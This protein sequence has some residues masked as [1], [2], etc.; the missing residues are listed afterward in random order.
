MLRELLLLTTTNKL[1]FASAIHGPYSAQ[2]HSNSV[3]AGELLSNN[4]SYKVTNNSTFEIQISPRDICGTERFQNARSRN[5]SLTNTS[6]AE[7][8]QELTLASNGERRAMMMAN[9]NKAASEMEALLNSGNNRRGL[10]SRPRA[11]TT[12]DTG[13]SRNLT[14]L[15]L[16]AYLQ[17]HGISLEQYLQNAKIDDDYLQRLRLALGSLPENNNYEHVQQELKPIERFFR[18]LARHLDLTLADLDHVWSEDL[19]LPYINSRIT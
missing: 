7:Y 4:G 9:L 6:A 16:E 15:G 2:R 19:R 17:Q 1:I 10:P 12:E 11:A 3:R 14:S 5:G 8:F 18:S 13:P